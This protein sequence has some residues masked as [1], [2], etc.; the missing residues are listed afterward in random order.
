[1]GVS[2]CIGP[3]V[4]GFECPKPTIPVEKRGYPIAFVSQVKPNSTLEVG[5]VLPEESL[6]KQFDMKNYVASAIFW[7]VIIFILGFLAKSI[8]TRYFVKR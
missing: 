4:V 8:H 6:D 1:M 5:Y 3:T 7:G 2:L